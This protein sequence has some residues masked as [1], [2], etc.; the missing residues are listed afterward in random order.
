MREYIFLFKENGTDDRDCVRYIDLENLKEN[1][2]CIDGKF[3]VYGACYSMSLKEKDADYENI[4]T[5]LTKEE[6]KMLCNPTGQDLTE[7]IKKLESEEN[8]ELFERVIEEEKEYL[9]DKYNLDEN[10][11]ETIFDNYG[12]D[13]RDRAVV[14]YVYDDAYDLGYEEAW[15]LGYVNDNDSISSRYFDF[16]S[17]GEDLVNNDECY[18][19]LADGRCVSLMY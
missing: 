10:D 13:Y 11:I 18:C 19:Q 1:H 7:I 9:M 2:T 12:L 4:T 8:Q 16:E 15:S 3:N 14:G 17:F 6:Y 5:I